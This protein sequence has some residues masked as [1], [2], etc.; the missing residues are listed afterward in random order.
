MFS[1]PCRGNLGYRRSSSDRDGPYR[2]NTG[3]EYSPDDR[4]SPPPRGRSRSP[5]DFERKRHRKTP[6]RSRSKDRSPR[7]GAGGRNSRSP[8]PPPRSRFLAPQRPT[9]NPTPAAQNQSFQP[10]QQ[11]QNVDHPQI[12]AA[13]APIPTPAA[14]PTAVPAVAPVVAVMVPDGNLEELERL[15]QSEAESAARVRKL[16]VELERERIISHELENE[17]GNMHSEGKTKVEALRRHSDLLTALNTGVGRLVSAR[18]ELKAAEDALTSLYAEAAS[19][20]ER[21][22]DVVRRRRT[23][24]A[25]EVARVLPSRDGAN[26]GDTVGKEVLTNGL[27]DADDPASAYEAQEQYQ[28]HYQM[29]YVEQQGVSGVDAGANGGWGEQGDAF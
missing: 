16:E 12:Q 2:S 10:P 1:I 3:R 14:V 28:Q 17:L 26:G 4:Y 13:I 7:R 11:Q 8:G 6:S 22:A 9:A 23:E 25:V 15:R 19:Y 27:H 18:Q 24:P 21:T 5:S 20:L 29:Q